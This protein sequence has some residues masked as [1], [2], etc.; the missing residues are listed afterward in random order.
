MTF[1]GHKPAWL[2]ESLPYLY[3]LIGVLTITLLGNP[4]AL[5]SGL[6]L[7][8]A[9][10]LIWRMRREFRRA[11]AQQ[12]ADTASRALVPLCWRESFATG[13]PAIDDQH[14]DLFT[15]GNELIALVVQ[16]RSQGDVEL[17]LYELLWELEAHCDLEARHAAEAGHPITAE[18]VEAHRVMLERAKAMRDAYHAGQADFVD[19]VRFVA[20][21][22]L[23]KHVVEGDAELRAQPWPRF[24]RDR[25]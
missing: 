25:A 10:A 17:K 6:T 23:I 19:V 1:S 7:L 15:R 8:S 21:E 9:G 16:G 2:Y 24:L 14:R 11:L 4:I 13:H 12:Q 3:A 22:L 5:A 20:Y 18:H